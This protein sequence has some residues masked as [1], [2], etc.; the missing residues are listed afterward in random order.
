MS[1]KGENVVRLRLFDRSSR[2][3]PKKWNSALLV[4]GHET[5]TRRS[6]KISSSRK[7]SS[8]T[9]DFRET[10]LPDRYPWMV[11]GSAP[12]FCCTAA[13]F[14]AAASAAMRDEGEK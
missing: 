6:V 12:P 4:R 14:G 1:S 11:R 9:R 13:S 2:A 8:A 7:F 10:N 3:V 5:S